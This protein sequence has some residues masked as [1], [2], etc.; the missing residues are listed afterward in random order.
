MRMRAFPGGFVSYHPPEVQFGFGG[1]ETTNDA[2]IAR[3]FQAAEFGARRREL[4]IE[5]YHKCSFS[6]VISFNR[7][8]NCDRRF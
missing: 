6:L 5:F 4:V 1:N 2:A 8:T 3:R 7:S